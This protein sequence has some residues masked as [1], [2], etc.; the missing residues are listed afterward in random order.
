MCEKYPDMLDKNVWI[1]IGFTYHKGYFLIRIK[2][3]IGICLGCAKHLDHRISA[4][5]FECK[6]PRPVDWTTGNKSL[7]LFIMK[8]WSNT[9]NV[10][11]SYIQWIK[12]SQLTDIQE[13]PLLLRHDCTHT[14]NL[15]VSRENEN[16]V[17][18][19]TLKKLV[20]GQDSQS[21]DFN[22]VSISCFILTL[23]E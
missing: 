11:D 5:C 2:D 9:M 14:A 16:K 23:L 17:I 18:K 20:D 12:H 3:G 7:D 8:S 10:F 21:Y 13:A 1:T 4:F 6:A 22:Q 19:V 15:L